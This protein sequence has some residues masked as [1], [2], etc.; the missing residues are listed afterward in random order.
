MKTFLILFLLGC[1]VSCASKFESNETEE[2]RP[3]EFPS[4][5]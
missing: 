2:E 1:L 5:V 3:R 4:R